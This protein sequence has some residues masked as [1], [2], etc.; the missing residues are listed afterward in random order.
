M[1]KDIALYVGK[2]LTCSKVKAEHRK[3]SGL[4][5]QPE[6]PLLKWDQ[7]SMD[8]IT[9]LPRTT[10]KHDSIWVIIDRL[11][12]SANFIPVSE[13]YKMESYHTSIKC[14]P[15]EALYG[16]KCRTPICWTKIGDS[17]VI[18]PEIVQATSDKIAIIQERLKAA[19][20]RQKSYADNRR[21][22]LEFQVGD[23]VLI[24]VPP[25]KVLSDL[26]KKENSLLGMLDLLRF[27][28]G[29]V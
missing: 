21:K 25:G 5:Q 7:I 20:D 22:P 2:C 1:K 4:L 11:T 13:T 19:R 26:G 28:K 14:A 12:K 17:Q 15:F 9:K 3:P 8:F 16:R 27:L 10:R 6:I 24:K 18:G 29:L 23:R